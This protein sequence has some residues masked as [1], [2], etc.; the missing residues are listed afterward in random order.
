[1]RDDIRF[2][3]SNTAR[4]FGDP[5]GSPRRVLRIKTHENSTKEMAIPFGVGCRGLVGVVTEPL[6]SFLRMYDK[7]FASLSTPE[8]RKKGTI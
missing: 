8:P 7:F 5:L 2:V 4:L 1:M 6:H 3:D